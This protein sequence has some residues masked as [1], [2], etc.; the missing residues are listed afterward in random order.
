M[1]KYK[2]ERESGQ[3][4][5]VIQGQKGQQISEREYYAL[6]TGQVKGLV[7]AQLI[8]KGKSFKIKYNI[9]GYISLR[10]YLYNP[11]NKASFVL[12][13]SNILENLKS[14]QK[15]Y[16]TYQYILMDMNA[17]M[18]NP[19]THEVSFV[20]VPITFFES[21]AN[22]KDFLLGIIQ[23]CTFAQG[24]NTEYVR[25]YIQILNRGI[26]FSLFELEEYVK[27]LRDS[28]NPSQAKICSKCGNVLQNE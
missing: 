4:F 21:G 28:S 8:E 23:C 25:E 10:E 17:A 11:L 12:L 1:N 7:M 18:V 14:L 5:L 3:T 6:S 27:R 9:S 26:N 22:L 24:E 15:A 13:L 20:Y 16:F 19:A 2:I